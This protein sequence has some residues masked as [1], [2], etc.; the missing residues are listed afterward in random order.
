M[1]F[2]R[3]IYEIGIEI[4]IKKGW[5]NKGCIKKIFIIF[6]TIKQNSFLIIKGP[7]YRA[8]ISAQEQVQQQYLQRSPQCHHSH[9][10][11]FKSTL[12]VINHQSTI[13]EC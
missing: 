6:T 7:F 4:C 12:S 1:F 8:M 13:N 11:P 3:E 2:V 5:F 9:G 10:S